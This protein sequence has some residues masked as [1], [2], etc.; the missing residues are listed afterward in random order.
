MIEISPV[1]V[2]EDNYVWLLRDTLLAGVVVVDPGADEPLFSLLERKRWVPIA[3][4]LTH[5]H[6]DHVDGVAN[7]RRHFDVPV[8]GHPHPATAKMITHP[9]YEGDVIGF[10]PLAAT[11]TVLE[12]PGHTK[13]HVAYYGHHALFCGDTLFSAGCGNISDGSLS[14][15]FAS[16]TRLATMPTETRCFFGHEYSLES[17]RFA[18]RVE[19][20]NVAV[21]TRLKEVEAALDQGA[22][23]MPPTT[24][25]E[26]LQWNPFLRCDQETV[27]LKAQEVVGRTLQTPEE[28]FVVLRQWR[29]RL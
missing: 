23:F 16:L 19:P 3:V 17:L 22:I 29:D 26:E 28:V 12:I 11:L 18:Q 24:L 8:Y 21:Q 2:R 6:D 4:L 5:H 25:A 13:D 1:L 14:H 7:L 9:V 10:P 15:L 20:M 27:K